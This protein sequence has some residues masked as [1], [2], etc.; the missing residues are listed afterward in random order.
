MSNNSSLISMKQVTRL[1]GD[2]IGV[3]DISLEL[4]PGAYGLLG[5]N[6]SGK[7]TLLNLITGRLHPTIGTISILGLEPWNNAE[8]YRHIGMS[9]SVSQLYPNISA[10][11]WVIYLLKLQGRSKSQAKKEAERALDLVKMTAAMHR[12]MGEYSRGMQQRTKLAQAIAHE[13]ELLILDEPFSG[14]DPIGRHDLTEILKH[15]IKQG[16]SVILASHILHEVEAVTDS[17][18]LIYGGRLLASGSA[19]EVH[20]MMVDVPN[21]ISL[22]CS[23][24]DLLSR[25]FIGDPAVESVQID[26]ESSTL[27]VSTKSSRSFYEALPRWVKETETSISEVR[28]SDES[29]QDLFESLLRI[30]RGEK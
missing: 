5:P 16:K 19:E 1:Y 18:L 2:V 20:S 28:S 24:P 15:Q 11:D 21:E 7:T 3:N 10:Y 9:P 13:P 6:G 23:N 14:L 12:K 8:L 17:F 30:H 27:T 26:R 22:K 25:H 4:P 29:L